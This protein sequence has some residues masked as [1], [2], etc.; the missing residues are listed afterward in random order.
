[1]TQPPNIGSAPTGKEMAAGNEA[2]IGWLASR[3]KF[4]RKTLSLRQRLVGGMEQGCLSS[5]AAII[6]Y[7]PAQALGI[8][9]EFWGAITAIAV[10]QSE[11]KATRST[12]RD[13]LMGAGVGGVI[14]L[15]VLFALGEGLASYGLAVVLSLLACWLL[16][17][18]SAARLAGITATI[19]LLVPHTGSPER[20]FL[21]RISE[22]G[23]GICVAIS[24]V[25]CVH[26][27]RK[28]LKGGLAA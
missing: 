19:I 11:Y 10:L 4:L 7:I 14:A 18:G 15:A 26:R 9:E 1:M 20:M 21:S 25:W 8:K 5:A 23:W 27:V 17:V 24:I 22:V 3:L 12:A 28:A 6:A 13:Q 2:H 16:N